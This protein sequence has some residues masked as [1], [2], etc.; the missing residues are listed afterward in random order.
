M[1]GSD[2]DGIA[3]HEAL[4]AWHESPAKRSAIGAVV[5][6]AKPFSDFRAAA[7]SIARGRGRSSDWKLI[8]D[9]DRYGSWPS[10]ASVAQSAATKPGLLFRHEMAALGDGAKVAWQ[11][12]RARVTW[13]DGCVAIGAPPSHIAGSYR[14]VDDLGVNN[15]GALAWL[16]RTVPDHVGET[17]G[18][19]TDRHDLTNYFHWLT[20]AVRA[21]MAP[22]DRGLLGRLDRLIICLPRERLGFTHDSLCALG[23]EKSVSICIAPFDASFDR[24]LITTPVQLSLALP[25]DVYARLLR[26][27]LGLD[28]PARARGRRLLVS[29]HDATTRRVTND[30]ELAAALRASGFE[31]V[32]PGQLTFG[33]QVEIFSSAEFVVAPH[34]AALANLLFCT[35]GTRVLEFPRRNR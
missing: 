11:L 30:Q 20:G 9:A 21:A 13:R 27:Q 12:E 26:R 28:R 8:A 15:G 7:E 29:R 5:A 6:A 32:A 14:Y 25:V 17:V 16:D 31:I 10:I 1:A 19:F 23:L 34:G 33:E 18:V 3:L 22:E 4:R 35:P 2:D 24:V